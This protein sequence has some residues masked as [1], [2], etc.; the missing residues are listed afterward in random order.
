MAV[1]LEGTVFRLIR[2]LAPIQGRLVLVAQSSVRKLELYW[3][4]LKKWA[5]WLLP[6]TA[7][8]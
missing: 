7:R 4:V 2:C 8:V 6:G 3:T 5:L 1:L